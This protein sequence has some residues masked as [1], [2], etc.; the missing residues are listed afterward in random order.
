MGPHME[1]RLRLALST[2]NSVS[3]KQS[4]WKR[5]IA[6]H[7]SI[8]TK[9]ATSFPK[10]TVASRSTSCNEPCVSRV[11]G[12]QYTEFFDR[13]TSPDWLQPLEQARFLR[14]R[15]LIRG[16]RKSGRFPVWAASRYLTRMATLE[17]AQERVFRIASTIPETENVSVHEDLLKIALAFTLTLPL[18]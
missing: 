7:P 12:A 5:W 6:V 17:V 14:I 13:L 8:L 18:L 11:W 10:V 3:W 9:S 15:R 16:E 1:V 4:Y 2:K